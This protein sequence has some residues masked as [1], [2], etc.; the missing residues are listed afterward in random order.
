MKKPEEIKSEEDLR[1]YP[2]IVF[3]NLGDEDNLV[4]VMHFKSIR[5][6]EAY[7]EVMKKER[8]GYY[9]VDVPPFMYEE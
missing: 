3:A 8:P 1:E 7:I 4:P 2:N 6:A 9:C 5:E